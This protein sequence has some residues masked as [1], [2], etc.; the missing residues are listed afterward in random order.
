MATMQDQENPASGEKTGDFEIARITVRTLRRAK[1]WSLVLF[2][3]GIESTILPKDQ[4][5]GWML[6]V[7]SSEMNEALRVLK[8]YQKE[9]PKQPWSRN[10]LGTGV[11]FDWAS[12]GWVTICIIFHWLNF[13][14]S[15]WREVGVMDSGKV[16]AGQWWR[17]VTA[18]FLHADVAHL[19]QNMAIGFVLMGLAMGMYGK[20]KA[21]LAALLTGIAGNALSLLLNPRPFN[22]LGA[23]G[24]IMGC[25]GLITTHSWIPSDCKPSPTAQ[26]W[27]L[28]GVGA[29]VALFIMLGTSPGTDIF[30]HTGGFVSGLMIGIAY[31]WLPL[32]YK[33]SKV[34]SFMAGFSAI[35]FT[36]IVWWLAWRSLEANH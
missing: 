26:K 16:L 10:F 8:L 32:S 3:Q 34:L 1:D 33:Q 18:L 9:N 25:L 35:G 4:N 29:A 22:G 7:K 6:E 28:T 31:A 36:G 20:S 30:A 24:L 2:S 12:L 14:N 5:D 19:A 15:A 27:M 13:G 23:S 21:L 17:M 11:V